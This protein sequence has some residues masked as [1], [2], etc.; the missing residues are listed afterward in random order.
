[1]VSNTFGNH[2]FQLQIL[3]SVPA[4]V[5]RLGLVSRAWL[6]LGR[7]TEDV[8]V[9][10]QQR[11]VYKNIHNAKIAQWFQP[12][13]KPSTKL[14]FMGKV[15]GGNLSAPNSHQLKNRAPVEVFFF[16]FVVGIR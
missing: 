15:V 7:A 6:S 5:E 10:F 2:L 13:V 9:T 14:L 16:F 1:M 8:Q 12:A 4:S 11:H 3:F